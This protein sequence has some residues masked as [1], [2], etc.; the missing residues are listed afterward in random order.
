MDRKTGYKLN[1]LN[2]I[3]KISIRTNLLIISII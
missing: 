3:Y 1:K 2:P